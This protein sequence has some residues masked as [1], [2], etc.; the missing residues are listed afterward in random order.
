MGFEDLEVGTEDGP[1]AEN[2]RS[3]VQYIVLN[4]NIGGLASPAPVDHVFAWA[5]W[6]YVPNGFIAK[7]SA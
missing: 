1:A 3:T 4:Y 7:R 5:P 6:P 2:R